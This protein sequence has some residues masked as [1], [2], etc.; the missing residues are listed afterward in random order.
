[1]AY[2]MQLE[3]TDAF[4]I[5]RESEK[6]RE[7]YGDHDPRPP[8]PHRPSPRRAWRAVHPARHGAGQP[9]DSHDDLE[10]NQ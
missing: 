4:D 6:T 9:W 3:A 10:K 8:V 2:R 7:M 1:M 5:G